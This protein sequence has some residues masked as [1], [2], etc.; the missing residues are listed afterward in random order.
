M[1]FRGKSICILF[2]RK[3]R[4][5]FHCHNNPGQW[6]MN[7]NILV[8][9]IGDWWMVGLDDLVGLFQPW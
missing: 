6:I 7:I 8:R 2:K 3:K 1:Q 4:R 9:T 5:Y